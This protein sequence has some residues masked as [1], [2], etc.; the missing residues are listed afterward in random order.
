MSVALL[1]PGQGSQQPKM[2]GSL[3]V[4]PAV[5]AVVDESHS[6]LADHHLTTDLDGPTALRDTTNVQL[7]LLIAGVACARALTDDHGLVPQFV[8]GHSVGAFAAAV[9]AGVLTLTEALAAVQIRGEMMKQ[10]C[11]TGDWGMAALTGL[12]TH[13]AI[14][15]AERVHIDT[16]P[17]WVANVNSATQTVASGSLRALANMSRAA[18]AAGAADFALLDVAVASH[19][20][21]QAGTA[22]ALTRHLAGLPLRAPTAGYL[23]NTRGRA[24]STAEAILAD[25]AQAVA[26]PIQWYDATR[27]MPEL[28]VTSGVETRPGHVLTR[29]N[30]SNAPGV[31][32]LSLQDDGLDAVLARA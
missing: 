26:H 6:W 21:L 12:P 24:V 2:L 16:E 31:T 27:L 5:T 25:L 1:F 8:A 28:G 9:T 30:T 14:R 11:A 32:S 17:V 20:P 22:H 4:S 29:L 23:T 10:A 13:S 7:A 3:P 15:L 19:C 18:E